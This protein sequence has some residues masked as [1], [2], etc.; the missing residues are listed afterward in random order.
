MKGNCYLLRKIDCLATTCINFKPTQVFLKHV[1]MEK[2]NKGL[3]R[4]EIYHKE[5]TIL[6]PMSH[7]DHFNFFS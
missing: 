3:K 5:K 6:D 2:K 1:I 4:V 7:Y